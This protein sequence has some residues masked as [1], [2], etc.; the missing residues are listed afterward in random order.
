MEDSVHTNK[1]LRWS[2]KDMFT[3]LKRILNEGIKLLM[4]EQ[5]TTLG[6][7]FTMKMETLLTQRMI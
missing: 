2:E 5:I 4:T 7:I 6:N 3:L 1:S